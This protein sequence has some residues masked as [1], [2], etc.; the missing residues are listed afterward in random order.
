MIDLSLYTDIT[1]AQA[2]ATKEGRDLIALGN[3]LATDIETNIIS[4][5]SNSVTVTGNHLGVNNRFAV[6]GNEIVFITAT[7]SGTNTTFTIE[8]AKYGTKSQ[9]NS[10]YTGLFFRT[11]SIH[12]KLKRYE[13][14]TNNSSKTDLFPFNLESG[15][16]EL[17]DWNS[18]YKVRTGRTAVYIFKGFY[19]DLVLK[20]I[21]FTFD[22][23]SFKASYN[24]AEYVSLKVNDKFI[25]WFDKDIR[26]EIIFKNVYPKQ[27]LKDL[28]D[29]NE[30]LINYKNGMLETDYNQTN[31]LFSREYNTYGDILKAFVGTGVRI[32]FNELEQ[33]EISSDVI[34]SKVQLTTSVPVEDTDLINIEVS[35]EEQL[36]INDLQGEYYDRTPL[37][38]F[39]EL[40]NKHVDY[41]FNIDITGFSLLT[42]TTPRVFNLYTFTN[43][44]VAKRV[45][46]EDIVI[47][48]EQGGNDLEIHGK[49]M[50]VFDTGEVTIALGS[51]DK[52]SRLNEF[53]RVDYL[54][55]Q[56]YSTSKNWKM[57][58]VRNQLPIVY[59]HS[60][61]FTKDNISSN[62]M[63]PLRP[64]ITGSTE[65]NV[66]YT[67][68]SFGAATNL[69]TGEFTGFS[70]EIEGIYGSWNN[71]NLLYNKEIEQYDGVKPP[72]FM[73]S[74]R[75]TTAIGQGNDKFIKYNTFDN[76]QVE[77]LIEA[78]TDK[79]ATANITFKNNLTVTEAQILDLI[80]DTDI[81]QLGSFTFKVSEAKYNLMNVGDVIAL[82]TPTGS[83]TPAQS[84]EYYNNKDT[85]WVVTSLFAEGSDRYFTLNGTIKNTF[86]FIV[87]PST[88][89]VYLQE[90]Y[91]L[92]NPIIQNL[93]PFTEQNATSIEEYNRQEYKLDGKLLDFIGIQRMV[94][95]FSRGYNGITSKKYML[96]MTIR[97]KIQLQKY[98][99]IEITGDYTND[100]PTNTKWL[101][102]GETTRDFS[103][104]NKSEYIVMNINDFDADESFV[105]FNKLLQYRPILDDPNYNHQGNEGFVNENITDL[106]DLN[107]ISS[108]DTKY[109]Y[110]AFKPISE[111]DVVA[112]VKTFDGEPQTSDSG[113]VIVIDNIE[114]NGTTFNI[115]WLKKTGEYRILKIGVEYILCTIASF[116]T[117]EVTFKIVKRQLANSNPDLIGT[118]KKVSFAEIIS[119]NI[120]G[121]L[122]TQSVSVGNTD[123]FMRFKEED[124]LKVQSQNVLIQTLSGSNVENLIQF[125][126]NQGKIEIAKSGTQGIFSVGNVASDDFIKYT[127]GDGLTLKGNVDISGGSINISTNDSEIKFDATNSYIKLNKTGTASNNTLLEI[128]QSTDD[129]YFLFGKSSTIIKSNSITMNG[130]L[131]S[132]TSANNSIVLRND[133]DNSHIK[134]NDEK[135]IIDKDN[136][137]VRNNKTTPTQFINFGLAGSLNIQSDNIVMNGG[138]ITLATGT[139]S[140]LL[141]KI[142]TSHIK[143]NS[144]KLILDNNGIWL[145]NTLITPT[146][147]FKFDILNNKLAIKS[148]DITMTGGSIQLNGDLVTIQNTNNILSFTTDNKSSIKLNK[149]GTHYQQ[150][151]GN[152]ISDTS[153]VYN[154]FFVGNPDLSTNKFIKFNIAE[155]NFEFGEEVN[156]QGR[157]I[158]GEN[159][160][161]DA[162]GV[163]EL[164]TTLN[165]NYLTWGS[166]SLAV[167]SG[168]IEMLGGSIT[169]ATTGNVNSIFLTNANNDSHLRLNNNQIQ[170]GKITGL[171]GKADFTGI[172]LGDKLLSNNK[173]LYYDV[174]GDLEIKTNK[175][176]IG[177][178][179]TYFDITNGEVFIGSSEANSNIFQVGLTTG[180][181]IG[182]DGT[183]IALKATNVDIS[184]DITMTGG[185]IDLGSGSNRIFLSE[186]VNNSLI[187]LNSDKIILDS[188]GLWLRDN[189]TTPTSEF[190]FDILNNKLTI[191]TNDVNIT[192]GE[193]NLQ[194]G[195]DQIKLTNVVNQSVI[196]LAGES[197]ILNNAGIL[198]KAGT[199]GGWI[200]EENLLKS[201]TTG[202]RI[203]LN[204]AKNRTSVFDSVNEKV[205]MGY[206]EGLPKNDGTGN[207]GAGDYGFWAREGDKLRIDGD[208]EYINGDW[209][210]RNDASYL[211]ED[212]SLNTIVRLGTDSG[213][214]GLFIYNTSGVR[215]AEYSSSKIYIGSATQYLEYDNTLGTLKIKGNVDI[216]SGT[217]FNRVFRQD[218]EPTGTFNTGDVWIDTND[219]D[220]LYTY[221]GSAW[222]LSQDSATAQTTANTA[223][224][225]AA[226]AQNAA[227][228]AQ[229]SAN[230]A[231]S[232]LSDIANDDK[233]TPNEKQATKKE[234]DIIQSEKTKIESEADV[235]GVSKTNYINAYNALD[236]YI[237]PLLSNLTTTSTIDGVVFRATFKAYYDERQLI[238]NAISSKAKDLADNAQT[239]ANTA[240]TTA[241]GKNTIFYT[242]STE[243]PLA[244]KVGDMWVQTDTD[245]VYTATATGAGGWVISA[246]NNK[247]KVNYSEVSIGEN[248]V[249]TGKHGFKVTTDGW[250]DINNTN[251]R[252]YFDKDSGANSYI[253][254]AN[255]GV[256]G[257]FTVGNT[258]LDEYIQWKDGT[259]K[260][261]GEIDIT[262]GTGFTKSFLSTTKPTTFNEGDIWINP[263]N[264][265]EIWRANADSTVDTGYGVEGYGEVPYGD[266]WQL[267]G[268][269]NSRSIT[270]TTLKMGEASVLD[271][272]GV[273]REG[274]NVSTNGYA[275]I[276]N[277][278]NELYFTPNS[279][280][281][282]YSLLEL[283]KNGTFGKFSV[284]NTSGSRYI[285][286]QNGQLTIAGNITITG[287]SGIA[288]L[289]DAGALA[290]AN[291]LDDVTDGSVHKKTTQNE[292]TGA[293][294]AFTG[295]DVNSAL[296]TSVLPG[297]PIGTPLS[298]GLFLGSDYL[299][300]YNG[301]WTSYIKSDGSFAFT[302]DVDNKI[303]WDGST[304]L[305]KSDTIEM[306]GGSIDLSTTDNISQIKL[307]DVADDSYIKLNN[308]KTILN[309]EGLYVADNSIWA[310][311]DSGL[312]LNTGSSSK[313]EIKSDN[314]SMTGGSITLATGTDTIS[315]NKT[316]TS[317]IRL[318][319]NKIILGYGIDSTKKGLYI[320]NHATWTS[321][322][323][324]L[325]FNTTDNKLD[326]ISDN[327]SMTGGNITLTAGNI[328]MN[329]L[330]NKLN[331]TESTGEIEIG[332]D[333]TGGKLTVGNSANA[334]YFGWVS[335]SLTIKSTNV[336]IG[337][338]SVRIESGNSDVLLSDIASASYMTLNDNK[339]VLDNNGLY[340]A[341]HA[342]WATAKNGIRV[343]VT[344]PKIDLKSEG[345]I[346]IKNDINSLLFS[347]SDNSTTANSHLRMNKITGTQ[348]HAAQ[349]GR[350]HIGFEEADTF[351]NGMYFGSENIAS[352]D[353]NYIYYNGTDLEIFTKKIKIKS[354][355]VFF[356][357]GAG[358]SPSLSGNNNVGIG[359]NSL[360]ANTSGGNNIAIG[361][362]SLN[363]NTTGGN[364]IAFGLNSLAKNTTADENI[365]IGTNSLSENTTG[366]RNIAMG[367]DSLKNNVDGNHNISLG[368]F[369]LENNTDGS[370]N[371]SIGSFSLR[372]NNTGYFN[373]AIGKNSMISNT[374]G[375]LNTAIGSSSLA[376][377][378]TGL[379][380]TAIG[381]GS[382]ANNT[383]S[384]N[385]AVG[386]HSLHGNTT[387]AGNVA[388]GESCLSN[389]VSG[390]NNIA[391]G[392]DAISSSTTVSNEI[393]LGNSSITVLRCNVT[394]ITSLSDKRDK[395]DIQDINLGL[396][397]VKE[398]KPSTFT[399]DR[400][401][402][403][404][405]DKKAVG[406]I[407]Q[408]L[409]E[410]VEKYDAKHTDLVYENNPDKL[411]V[412]EGKLIPILTKAIQE[413]QEIIEKLIKRIDKL[414]GGK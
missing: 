124:G 218:N 354:T 104:G 262:S 260:I 414:E 253:R 209:I 332:I 19:D 143:L 79:K 411:E 211:V 96:P 363:K 73:L 172:F 293:G 173:Y 54:H 112:K 223:I 376:A 235:F 122:T 6:M 30:G 63:I 252:I 324:G 375:F 365:A 361:I 107:V 249:D 217:G 178:T 91:I 320:A 393:T 204:K 165:D 130:G 299:G 177:S 370:D 98:D 167:K 41:R 251:N 176:F 269:N 388:V 268:T 237:T 40:N 4:V 408:D 398:L 135:I 20:H 344:T 97:N 261:R 292:K 94:D 255:N 12:T 390:S 409:L 280:L 290:V 347:S 264:E 179:T 326:I 338:G 86:D 383:A 106:S 192:G 100:L 276:T 139:D 359:I 298:P 366:I 401:D 141:N 395:K 51:W 200:L 118:G 305:V 352:L 353:A 90:F 138:S 410:I 49:V 27:F 310:S 3:V 321:A 17:Y 11:V 272:Y 82:K 2:S 387:G 185:S 206:L 174:A 266:H 313:L 111:G 377:N 360:N 203:E 9:I 52:D 24:R 121:A 216:V 373:I 386:R 5:S 327:I 302:G 385:T 140:I 37:Y 168:S 295:L 404:F 134:L 214:K 281:V 155:G 225:D 258:S 25:K 351:F 42:S 57:Y 186:T 29:Y 369:S 239:S 248:A 53:G 336:V 77:V 349:I 325:R 224:S 282:D 323:A 367:M 381:N 374:T 187:K 271:K 85:N 8:R 22:K 152:D 267:V 342:T 227:D 147:E 43:N 340:V 270:Y 297:S 301:A 233:L 129:N 355:N 232:L 71:T 189:T 413:Q 161:V 126:D 311:A 384:N 402:G 316:N 156:I 335:N 202:A 219:N 242:V 50:E 208:G 339:I 56:G 236:S 328:T 250:V 15:L 146:S 92:G 157:V 222:V 345:D 199:I 21:G 88:S 158:S 190:K 197:V 34:A 337:G 89:I 175:G 389:L 64:Q 341:D 193:I 378:L 132:L 103:N 405:K 45:K 69:E 33:L 277:S 346:E 196:N 201:Q 119:I 391:I 358:V 183:N 234:W 257:E 238:L 318:D 166:E 145:R 47:F 35:E 256:N 58:Y 382:L 254:L 1:N 399:W 169:L 308:G 356:G 70:E 243:T 285:N 364:N 55:S 279:N 81:E 333:G 136:F 241:D 288:S 259:L 151:L 28:L 60:D 300:Y 162:N 396:N 220:K 159:L 283:D 348:Y 13:Y 205:A 48:K 195:T 153:G 392:K 31:Y 181:Y 213:E 291:N 115:D 171:T 380:N 265:E 397:F 334:N 83:L 230:T 68:A 160:K 210:I 65:L 180:N 108:Q 14:S 412:S 182:F 127:T 322:T 128:N 87:Y 329:T 350:V 154:G 170:L 105:N 23:K 294:R 125:Q 149:S 75:I 368:V 240:Q 286:Y 39:E 164:G 110:V 123:S 228:N 343:N 226:T 109:G 150:Q 403:S 62:M 278:N 10:F 331:F 215:L 400:R 84:L 407:A 394:T 80:Q 275:R 131:I 76:S 66:L 362:T 44:T 229:T 406:F 207:W 95:Y 319:T 120:D 307:S 188:N 46:Q 371:I 245:D 317:Q 273:F 284:G 93:S 116:T 330:N 303:V 379:Q 117:T 148:D 133:T 61:S 67:E 74:N 296:T 114:G 78:P 184:G 306:S 263:Q 309:S 198:A 244:L 26:D 59:K 16:V 357:E 247:T 231:N 99:V 314:I 113:D 32:N 163:F 36:I 274:F 38:N 312:R 7:S 289:S 304:L 221:T 194:A 18:N 191:K 144:E 72:I 212:A 246:T 287:G 372:A 315:L 102:L 101:I 142:G 137:I